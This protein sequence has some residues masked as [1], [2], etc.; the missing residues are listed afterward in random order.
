MAGVDYL[1]EKHQYSHAGHNAA[2]ACEK[3]ACDRMF[4]P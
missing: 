1:S 2:N 3:L 4:N